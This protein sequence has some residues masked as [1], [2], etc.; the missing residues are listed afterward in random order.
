MD[1][2]LDIFMY[3]IDISL[4]DQYISINESVAVKQEANSTVYR[5]E[6]IFMDLGGF[7]RL[8]GPWRWTKALDLDFGCWLIDF[9]RLLPFCCC[10]HFLNWCSDKIVPKQ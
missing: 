9:W 7:W 2:K 5:C 4:Y 8:D 3:N 1:T 6:Y 10:L